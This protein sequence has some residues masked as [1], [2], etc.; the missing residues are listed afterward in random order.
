MG[1]EFPNR[2]SA[3]ILDLQKGRAD[4][5]VIEYS[6]STAI[7]ITA[8]NCEANGKQYSLASAASHT[9]TSLAAGFDL[10][11]VYIDDDV[12]SPPTPTFIDS[13]TEP[14]YSLAK[15]GWYNGDDRCVGVVVSPAT[16]ATVLLFETSGRDKLISVEYGYNTVPDM[17]LNIAADGTWKTPTNDGDVV[18]PVGSERI[19]AQ[20]FS[21]RSGAPSQARMATKEMVDAGLSVNNSQLWTQGY[22]NNHHIIELNLGASRQI[23]ISSPTG[24]LNQLTLRCMGF[25]YSR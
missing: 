5:F 19:R 12:S 16:G 11:Y 1:I 24:N 20:L 7:N 15:R 2:D 4:G 22:I 17:A 14:V 25:T 10:H 13:T 21:A 6:T 18:V 9:M 3:A 23:R 8:G